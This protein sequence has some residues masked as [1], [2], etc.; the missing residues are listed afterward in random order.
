MKII[1]SIIATVVALVL[2]A[3][4]GGFVLSKLWVWFMVPI[5]DLNP[6]R[7]VEAIGLTFIVGYMINNPTESGKTFEGP[8]LEELLK[9]FLQTLVMAAGFLLIGWIIHLFM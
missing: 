2:G 7:I 1:G 5:F 6:L 8:F 3:I 9:A 4:M